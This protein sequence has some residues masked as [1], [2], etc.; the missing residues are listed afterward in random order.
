MQSFS[1]IPFMASEK[2]FE[3][4]FRT[5]SL[6]VA[7]NQSKSVIWTKSI[8]LVEDYSRNISVKLFTKYLQ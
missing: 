6:L 1:F 2:I 5:F 4:F 3:Y 7:I 8:W